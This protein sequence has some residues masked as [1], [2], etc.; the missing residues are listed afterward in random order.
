MSAFVRPDFDQIK[1]KPANW[2]GRLTTKT[3]TG[4]V[5]RRVNA[6]RERGQRKKDSIPRPTDKLMYLEPATL[7]APQSLLG[8]QITICGQ[9]ILAQS[10]GHIG[11]FL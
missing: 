6:R 2:R 9:E 5:Q 4:Q 7:P 8:Q 11:N 1:I 3:S 10:A